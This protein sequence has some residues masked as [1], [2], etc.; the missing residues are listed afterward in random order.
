MAGRRI[1]AI[2][3]AAVLIASA[4]TASEPAGGDG[5]GEAASTS[6][7]SAPTTTTTTE[8]P[9]LDVDRLVLVDNAGRVVAVDR[10]GGD[11]IVL[12]G[13]AELPFQPV[14]SPDGTRIAYASRAASP[15]F[16]I[17]NPATGDQDRVDTGS[18]SFYFYWSPAGNRLGSL[19]NG[20]TGIVFEIVAVDEGLSIGEVDTGQ[21]YYFSWSPEGDRVAVHVGANRFDVVSAVAQAAEPAPLAESPGLFRAPQWVA[22]GVVAVLER[23]G[24]QQIAM[25]SADGAETPIVPVEGGVEFEASPDGRRIAVMTFRP[26]DGNSVSAMLQAQEAL[27]ANRLHVVDVSTGEAEQVTD[28]PAIAFFWSPDSQKLLVMGA[29]EEQGEVQWTVWEEG[30]ATPG[31]SFR[32]STSWVTEFLP[33]YDQYAQ[34]MR[35]WSP[36]STAYTFPGRIGDDT[37][38][39]VA[40]AGGGS[41]DLIGTGSWVSWSQN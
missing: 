11:P 26:D 35:V 12:S 37:G 15:G 14:W 30:V 38:I 28:E 27:T 20:P 8:A 3:A 6:T 24:G 21:P 31:P 13:D 29:G 32:P 40:P 25:I 19:R 5:P 33:F 10:E 34:S 36:D 41:P 17:V 18:A 9:A 22:D 23:N 4:C 7:T 16:V 1:A 2:T 39:W